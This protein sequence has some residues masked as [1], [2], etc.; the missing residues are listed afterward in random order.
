[1][2]QNLF[3]RFLATEARF[4]E[5]VAV[6]VQSHSGV[7]EYT[8]ADLR[9]MAAR[10]AAT[11]RARGLAAGERCA[12][13]ADNHARWCAAFL[14]IVGLGAVAVPLDTTL[15]PAQIATLLRDSGAHA[16]FTSGPYLAGVRT[17]AA[18]CHELRDILMLEDLTPAVLQRRGPELPA[19][20]ARPEDLA[21]ILYTS[22]TTSDPKGV[23][24]THANL[25]AETEAVFQT[26][27]VNEEDR[28]L[29]V[30]PLFHAL[31]LLANFWLPLAAGASVVF[32][33]SIS[34][35]EI[36]R[37]MREREVSI[38]V[39]VPQFFYLLHQRL[40]EQVRTAGRLRRWL[41]RSLLAVNGV[42]RRLGP[43]FGQLLF[44]QV[45]EVFGPRMRLLV[46]GGSRFD[47]AIGQGF[48]RLGFTLLQ[49]Y[50]LTEC[51]GAASVTPV[52]QNRIGSVGRALP[53]VE[54]KIL[55]AELNAVER[56]GSGEVAIRGPIVMQGY[57]QHPEATAA[58]LQDGW[59]LTG[60]LGYLDRDRNLFIT[61]RKKDVIVLSS[62]KN[63][64]PEEVEAHYAQSPL[65]QELC[66][67]GRTGQPSEP[68]AERLHAVVVPNFEVLRARKVVNAREI[69][70]FE[71]E[72]LSL[73]LPP[74]KRILSFE[75]WQNELPR[76]TTRKLKRFEI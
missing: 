40:T 37:A 14:G 57:Y 15:K 35:A 54:I 42:A 1:M 64:H 5:R 49:A 25:L 39:V 72:S 56:D 68:L 76:T 70:R 23:A 48:H 59:L 8:Y 73:E 63:I 4:A 30:L 38:F 29:G 11:L 12:L 47:P 7:E 13:L 10:T 16:I 9:R 20:P 17:A 69:L 26:I 27:P 18:A 53:G 2:M 44:R 58:V 43:N 19:S 24:L 22:G 32:L 66:V 31:A 62:G 50:G 71:I 75:L 28:I 55:P 74:H 41:F 51:S 36:L 67:L 61:G 46:T 52:E 34:S 3:E 33:H 60:D 6:I 21:S 65:I 45:H